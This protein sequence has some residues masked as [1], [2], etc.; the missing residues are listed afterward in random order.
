MR[1]SSDLGGILAMLTATLMFVVGD[2]FMKLATEDLPQFDLLFLRGIAASVAC[3]A[4]LVI[5][6]QWRL[7][8]GALNIRSLLRAAC[9]TLS[10]LI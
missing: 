5:F 3:V 7:L 9:E 8:T 10:T 2:S 1:K 6:G 4:L